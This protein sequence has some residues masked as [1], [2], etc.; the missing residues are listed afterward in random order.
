MKR[1]IK[2][3]IGLLLAALLLCGLL[4]MAAIAAEGDTHYYKV[5]SNVPWS[6]D[7]SDTALPF[8]K[9]T[10]TSDNSIISSKLMQS[11]I[12]SNYSTVESGITLDYVE[13]DGLKITYD[14]FAQYTSLTAIDVSSC[15][16][17]TGGSIRIRLSNENPQLQFN[18]I[19][20][21]GDI[22]IKYVF[23]SKSEG[24]TYSPAFAGDT[25]GLTSLYAG[26]VSSGAD[27]WY[28]S[29]PAESGEMA[30]AYWTWTSAADPTGNGGEKLTENPLTVELTE[31]REYT[32]H[33]L[34]V[35]TPSVTNADPDLGSAGAQLV[36]AGENGSVW[37]ITGTPVNFWCTFTHVTDSEGNRYES[38]DGAVEVTVTS[39][40]QEFTAHFEKY[41]DPHLLDDIKVGFLTGSPTYYVDSYSGQTVSNPPSV[42][43]THTASDGHPLGLVIPVEEQN[44]YVQ[45]YKYT[46]AYKGD[47]A[48]YS[49][50]TGRS[51]PS[52]MRYLCVP[53]DLEKLKAAENTVVVTFSGTTQLG[54]EFS[55]TKEYVIDVNSLTEAN[56]NTEL[57]QL[58]SGE[59]T[60][61][62]LNDVVTVTDSA[63]QVTTIYAVT[64]T[65]VFMRDTTGD[66]YT[67]TT[68]DGFSFGDPY[69]SNTGFMAFCADEDNAYALIK[70]I[71]NNLSVIDLARLGDDGAW[72]KVENARFYDGLESTF[73]GGNLNVRGM[74]I[75]NGKIRVF[76]NTFDAVWDGGK[77]TG[78]QHPEGLNI[79]YNSGW[80]RY[81]YSKGVFQTDGGFVAASSEGGIWKYSDGQWGQLTWSTNEGINEGLDPNTEF[82]P[83]SSALN[84]N[85]Y[86]KAGSDIYRISTSRLT[87]STCVKKIPL[88]TRYCDSLR[89]DSYAGEDY[90]GKVYVMVNGVSYYRYNSSWRGTY[91]YSVDMD[92]G[93]W[94]LENVG[95]D[96]YDYNSAGTNLHPCE[97]DRIFNPAEGLTV[98]GAM[99]GAYAIDTLPTGSVD[100]DTIRTTAKAE[101]KEYLD[102]LGDDNYS[103]EKYAAVLAAYE[104]GLKAIDAAADIDAVKAARDAAKSAMNA[105]EKDMQGTKTVW[106]SFS[107]D[108]EFIIGNDADST[109]MGAMEITVEYFDL[110]AYG[111]EAFYKYDDNGNIIEQPTMLHLYIKLLEEYYL[112]LTDGEQLKVG[113]SKL[114]PDDEYYA[115]LITGSASSMYMKNFWGHDENLT[116]FHNHQY[117]LMSPGW[118]STADWIL[119]EN[120]DYVELAM[121]TD[122]GFYRDEGAGFR[123]FVD[124]EGNDVNEFTGTSGSLTARR[125]KS[126]TNGGRS[127]V[128]EANAKIYYI[129]AEDFVG[130]AVSEGNGWTYLTTANGDGK[131]SFDLSSLEAGEYYL[132]TPGNTVSSPGAI[133]VTVPSVKYGDVNGDDVINARDAAMI[134]ACVNGEIELSD[135]QLA[136]ADV[137]GDGIVNARDAAAVYALANGR[138]ES[139]STVQ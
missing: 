6:D 3:L 42:D 57:T 130:G 45:N 71:E 61:E 65:V 107:N 117:P 94:T 88:D 47:E 120:G 8:L 51:F 84:G 22:S 134:Y 27:Q 95:G 76:G 2:R 96:F 82:T 32:A 125:A 13:V 26:A 93:L 97:I 121:Y 135:T 75:E 85:F 31:N 37:K 123:Y 18:N 15:P 92:T 49:E 114:K 54:E 40:G 80:R 12:I 4:P 52:N 11:F 43:T 77:W 78:T 36:R 83:Q 139:F 59:K 19:Q 132:G 68:T 29:A 81:V 21:T 74:T 112:G 24:Y 23:S 48:P 34:P 129:S 103:E 72:E 104:A 124:S 99:E 5:S 7:G 110:A 55:D 91:L 70:H 101:L 25:A 41:D 87:D 35:F 86:V 28:I 128:N 63:T 67:K 131:F 108:G 111:L 17:I 64:S 53:V 116:Y 66:S 30:F 46:I 98:F 126:D 109:G 9:K 79:A 58:D 100:I 89:L 1:N 105:V 50:Y 10:N 39:E 69:G 20:V 33:Y 119:L 56:V 122:W 113:E 60:I 138:I 62:Y 102:A 106:V 90:N 133:A 44:G 118:G 115:L 73:E 136:A 38:V 16:N 137:N 14:D 127:Y